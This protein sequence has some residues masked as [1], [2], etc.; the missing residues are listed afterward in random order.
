MILVRKLILSGNYW[1]ELKVVCFDV[2]VIK[3]LLY[4]H[5]YMVLFLFQADL[6]VA[7]L[8]RKSYETLNKKISIYFW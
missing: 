1:F 7:E 3:V 2:F 6:T 4:Q 5:I 8:S